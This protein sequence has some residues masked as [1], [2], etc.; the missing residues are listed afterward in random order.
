MHSFILRLWPI[1]LD[2]L[3]YKHCF[4]RANPNLEIIPTYGVITAYFEEELKLNLPNWWVKA[5]GKVTKY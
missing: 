2:N 4:K 1:I 3:Q 5:F